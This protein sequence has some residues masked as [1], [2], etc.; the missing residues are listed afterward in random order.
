MPRYASAPRWKIHQRDLAPDEQEQ[1][2]VACCPPERAVRLGTSQCTLVA[3]SKAQNGSGVSNH[4]P[5][6]GRRSLETAR[7]HA[8]LTIECRR[9]AR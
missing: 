5:P 9:R 2:D 6:L 1:E 7:Q 3:R 8:R 4:P